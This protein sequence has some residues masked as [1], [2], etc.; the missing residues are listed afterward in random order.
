MKHDGL[1]ITINRLMYVC[2]FGLTPLARNG[3]RQGGEGRASLT[4]AATKTNTAR[5]ST[6]QYIPAWGTMW[7]D[8]KFSKLTLLYSMHI[9]DDA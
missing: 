5:T 3:Y 6:T 1:L 2:L 7:R 9:Q 4:E 8:I